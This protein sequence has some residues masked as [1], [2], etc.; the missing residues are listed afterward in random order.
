MR[1]ITFFKTMLAAVLLLVGSVG[2][3][4]QGLETFENH[5]LSGTSY[6]DGSFV[7]DNGVIWNYV[8]VTGEQEYPINSKGILLR[9]SDKPSSITS[10]TISGGIG[11]FSMQMRKAFTSTG[12]RQVALYVN[13][14]HIA[15]SEVFGAAS[16]ADATIHT[17]TVD[18]I[19]ISGDII[20][21]IRHIT[22]N[23]SNR[24]LVI[25]NLSWTAYSSG[26]NPV[27]S[28]PSYSV[29][30]ELKSADTYF[31]TAN[32][33]ILSTTDGASIYYTT[34]GDAP[35]TASTLYSSPVAITS[36]TTFKAIAVKSGM[37]NSLVA[38]KTI[39]IVAPAVGTLPFEELFTSS[40]GDFYAYS[41]TGDQIWA[42]ASYTSGAYTKFAK[43]SGYSGG[44]KENEDWL[45]SPK[46]TA[47]A[48][49]GLQLSFASA[50]GFAGNALQL[51]YSTNYSGFG[52]PSNATW[53]DITS[54]A[55]WP[56]EN[57]SYAWV[58]SGNIVIAGTMPVH[59]AFVYT[60]TTTAAAT[61]EV[62]NV[63]VINVPAGPTITVTEVSV[64]AM[65]AMVG[66]SSTSTIHVSGI[67]L[68]ANVSLAVSGKNANRFS[69][70]PTSLTHTGGV[71]E[72]TEVTITYT[73]AAE[74]ADTATLTVSSAGASSVVFELTGKGVILTGTGTTENP[75]TVA[76]VKKLNNSFAS[77]T[78]YW[79]RGYIVG[80]PS[81][82]NAEGNLTTVDLE[83]EFTGATA[84]ALA[85]AETETDLTK[86][87][88]VQLPTG[89]V[90]TAL[91]LVDNPAN[92]KK[93]VKVYG[94]LEAYFT[95]APGVKNVSEYAFIETSLPKVDANDF[96]VY[97]S[98]GKLQVDAV[99]SSEIVVFDVIG[100]QI[101][102]GLL[103]A[104]NNAI[105]LP[106]RGVMVVKINN[107]TAKVVL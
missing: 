65:Q 85:D 98:A 83:P 107:S 12:D 60:S 56:A 47:S 13:G 81:A 38:E 8:Q 33:T 20:I 92:Y 14:N 5:A 95:A 59:F 55:S 44:N 2:L 101:Y 74:T 9:R 28:T 68:T 72:N 104:G 15:D 93:L 54:Q 63:K 43:M 37:D 7:G 88:G 77:A 39:N 103:Q 80:V 76:D 22:G 64:P 41:K 61:W 70:S 66:A 75:F 50:T 34:N 71:V 21:E 58:E 73:P 10:S 82:G 32:V 17:F 57:S 24:Q 26:G 35:T 96:K 102:K 36:T 46:F 3:M 40:L 49:L 42:A 105:N 19:N 27:A 4:S 48:A 91:N 90:R 16:G 94:T 52:D 78:K 79:V 11:S 86:M 53:T 29:S 84:I 100:K 99:E 25:D 89:A 45:I 106:H 69:V 51:K 18:N 31:N 67:N 1:K 97:T 87:I 23:T 62:A 30:G 6:V